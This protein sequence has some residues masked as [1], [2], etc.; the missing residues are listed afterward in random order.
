LGAVIYTK[1][2]LRWKTKVVVLLTQLF[3]YDH[4]NG[5]CI[6]YFLYEINFLTVMY[7][8]QINIRFNCLYTEIFGFPCC[9]VLFSYQDFH[10]VF[11]KWCNFANTKQINFKCLFI[12]PT[13]ILCF[14][15]KFWLNTFYFHCVLTSQCACCH[16]HNFED[17]SLQTKIR[18]NLYAQLQWCLKQYDKFLPESWSCIKTI[19]NSRK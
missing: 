10:F 12:R 9:S 3:K 15:P 14:P 1:K 18:V 5:Y 2:I 13:A 17:N 7:M 6:F 8:I 4:I 19:S 16:C 11:L